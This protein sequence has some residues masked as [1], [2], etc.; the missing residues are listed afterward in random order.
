MVF[1]CFYAT[2]NILNVVNFG[3]F[4]LSSVGGNSVNSN[5]FQVAPEPVFYRYRRLLSLYFI[6]FPTNIEFLC[7]KKVKC[8]MVLATSGVN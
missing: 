8:S 1:L 6:P 2:I 3:L 4:L 5:Q 7:G